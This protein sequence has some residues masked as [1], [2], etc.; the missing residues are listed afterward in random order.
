[1]N[2][3]PLRIGILGASRIA[4]AAIIRPARALGHELVAIGAR[5]QD[6]ATAYAREHGIQRAYGSYTQ[7]LDDPEVDIVFNGLPNGLHG[8]WTIASIAAGK[9]ALVEK[10]FASNAAEAEQVRSLAT[11]RPVVVMEAFH[12][13]YHP[14]MLRVEELLD[15]DAIGEITHAEIDMVMPPPAP[16]DPRWSYALAGGSMMDVGCYGVHL[17]RYLGRWLGGPPIIVQATARESRAN[18]GVDEELI[19]RTEYPSGATA[20]IHSGM[21]QRSVRFGFRLHG[22]RGTI[23][24][25]AFVLPMNDDRLIVSVKGGRFRRPSRRRVEHLGTT[26]TYTYQLQA[27]AGAVRH[28]VPVRNDLDDAVAQMAFIDAAYLAAGMAPRRAV[29]SGFDDSPG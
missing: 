13:L 6:R 2:A 5:D 25:P 26:P 9:H 7:V 20:R 8:P 24:A 23:D 4:P 12:Y 17:A 14:L 28:G 29:D 22:T 15:T 1:M 19:V 3:Q 16:S 11:G 10:P 18:P 21:R 27:F